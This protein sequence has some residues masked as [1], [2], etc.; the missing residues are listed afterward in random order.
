MRKILKKRHIQEAERYRDRIG[1]RI[2][3]PQKVPQDKRHLIKDDL[4]RF[5]RVLKLP[6]GARVLDVGCSDGTVT[7]EIAKK[8]SCRQ[9]IGVD[10]A[11]SA[12]REATQKIRLVKFACRKNVSFLNSFIEDLDF[13]DDYFDTVSA[14][15]VLE[16]LAVGQLVSTLNNLVRML[17]RSGNMIITVPNRQPAQKYIKQKRDRW[18]WPNHHRY[19]TVESL[20]FILNEYFKKITFYPLYDNEDYAKSIYLICNCER[21]R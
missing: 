1:D 9:V 8:P 18:D 2:L 14:G 3:H 17:S 11:P 15:E 10:V 12:I 21:K 5:K 16:H 20:R 19:F 7:I 13:S 6:F 4:Q